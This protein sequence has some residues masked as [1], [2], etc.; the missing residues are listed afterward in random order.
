[1]FV[2][3]GILCF[4]LAIVIVLAFLMLVGIDSKESSKA[5]ATL[6]PTIIGLLITGMFHIGIGQIIHSIRRQDYNTER[7]VSLLQQ[8]VDAKHK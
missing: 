4:C 7:M 2:W 8:I 3:A 6:I 5:I 1:M